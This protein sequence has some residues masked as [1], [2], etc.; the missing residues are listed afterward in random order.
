[1]D[2]RKVKKLIELLEKSGISDIEIHE[3]DD[4]VRISRGSLMSPSTSSAQTA[5]PE[6][7]PPIIQATPTEVSE[8]QLEGHVVKSPMV[9]VFYTAPTPDKPM[10]VEVGQRV[11]Q[12]Q[13][14]C[15]I[16]AM[17]VMNQIEADIS[18]VIKRV[19]PDNGEPIEY[20][21]SLFLIEP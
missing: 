13:V 6:P 19:F 10:F 20:G 18:G 12:G 16:E 3:G 11:S 8:P 2:I 5:L 17:K 15:I 7:T 9:G 1:M 21:Q 4:S 14:L